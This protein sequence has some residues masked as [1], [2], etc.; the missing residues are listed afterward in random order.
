MPLIDLK[1]NLK[2]LKYGRDKYQGGSSKQ[3]FVAAAIPATNEPL[4]TG[5]LF[6]DV[7]VSGSADVDTSKVK[8]AATIGAIVG[9]V[10]GI[11]TGGILAPAAI[12]T[13][14]ATG[15]AIGGGVGILSGDNNFDLDV[16]TDISYKRA[17][18]GT[19]GADF[20]IRGN[21]LLPNALVDDVTRLTK[22]FKSTNGVLFTIKQN[23]LSRI[24]ARPEYVKFG[25][26]SGGGLLNEGIYTPIG[27]ILGAVGSPFG[28][29]PNKQ[30]INPLAGLGNLFVG[31]R[32]AEKV[33]DDNSKIQLLLDSNDN[34]KNR[35]YGLY[36]YKISKQFTGPIRST[37][38]EG[39]LLNQND[40]S[41]N[42]NFI[43]SYQGGPN[44][45]LG[46]GKTSIS[47]ATDNTGTPLSVAKKG[48]NY[49]TDSSI[50]RNFATLDYNQ[51]STLGNTNRN[52]YFTQI[53]FRVT[54]KDQIAMAANSGYPISTLPS[55]SLYKSKNIESRTKKGDPGNPYDKNIAS[56]TIGDPD[57]IGTWI[58]TYPNGKR[59]EVKTP[60]G[61]VGAASPNS[62]D[63]LNAFGFGDLKSNAS[64]PDPFQDL[65]EFKI[66]IIDNVNPS[67]SPITIRFRAL[68][69]TISDAYTS[70]WDS[71]SYVGRG[72]K[73]YT[74]KGFDRKFSLGW[75][76]AATS[77]FEITAIYRKLNFLA[78]ICAPNYSSNG[79]MGGNII[80][81]TVGG[82]LYEQPGII[83]GLRLEM[84]NENDTWEIAIDDDGNIDR[85]AKQLPHIVRVKG[86]EFIPIHDFRPEIQKLNDFDPDNLSSI[87]KVFGPQKYISLQN[88]TDS[89]WELSNQTLDTSVIPDNNSSQIG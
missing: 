17:Q 39:R 37:S 77:K 7:N 73:F 64:G 8:K 70:D 21:L 76:V 58:Q 62:Y 69:D 22:F 13:G 49:T 14:A 31:Q 3:P 46:I 86:F 89:N 71:I 43:L 82:Y 19:G 29:H 79:Y 45:P 10:V 88:F 15:A 59:V 41:D 84:N 60:Y 1:T 9:G 80:K 4:P 25:V 36:Y 18:A 20:I 55:E 78:S 74:Y 16:S 44:A 27:T 57:Y 35:L 81:L 87:N 63:E 54:L 72:E 83:T 66:Q 61:Y 32:Y 85:T 47:Y 11:A 51:I 67:T 34:L 56:Y 33:F 53:D 30:G 52:G 68:L 38:T 6:V 48:I 26:F 28:F 12:L 23:L 65:V 50:T 5:E 42:D 2:D 24:A 75:T 40:I